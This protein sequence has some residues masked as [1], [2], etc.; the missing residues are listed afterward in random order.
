MMYRYTVENMGQGNFC[1]SSLRA[2]YTING[3][4]IYTFTRSCSDENEEDTCSENLDVTTDM[5]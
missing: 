5:F 1:K 2:D 4:I 3:K